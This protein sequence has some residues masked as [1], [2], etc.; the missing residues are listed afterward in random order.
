MQ[1]N[2]TGT[3]PP[4]PATQGDGPSPLLGLGKHHCAITY[5]DP[6][7]V[8]QWTGRQEW[9]VSFKCAMTGVGRKAWLDYAGVQNLIGAAFG[10]ADRHF[11]GPELVSQEVGLEVIEFSRKDGTRGLKVNPEGFY[12]TTTF[13]A[14]PE[15]P[16]YPIAADLQQAAT[17]AAPAAS[18]PFGG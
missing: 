16:A 1:V 15:P 3:A 7:V 12:S 2:P 5:V 9:C 8:N 17:P 6:N 14:A 13:Q 11:D 10:R 18:N 4:A